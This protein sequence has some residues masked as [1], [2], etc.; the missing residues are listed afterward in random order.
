MAPSAALAEWRDGGT[1]LSH[2]TAPFRTASILLAGEEWGV[3]P[4]KR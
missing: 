1:K 4:R 3:A 2:T